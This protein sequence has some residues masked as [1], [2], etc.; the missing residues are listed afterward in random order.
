ML[1]EGPKYDS[2]GVQYLGAFT[3][4]L[5]RDYAK[6]RSPVLVLPRCCNCCKKSVLGCE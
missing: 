4:L 1:P 2:H 6:T 3:H 5:G